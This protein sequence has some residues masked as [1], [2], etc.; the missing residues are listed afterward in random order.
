MRLLGKNEE[1]ALWQLGGDDCLGGEGTRDR[2]TPGSPYAV[3]S[4]PWP[5]ISL[6]HFS[7]CPGFPGMLVQET[8]SNLFFFFFF[9][10]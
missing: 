1:A 9:F 10:F 3:V 6:S 7:L 8:I 2:A 5:S 4:E